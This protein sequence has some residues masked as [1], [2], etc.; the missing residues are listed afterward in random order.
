MNPK[1]SVLVAAYNVSEYLEKCLESIAQQTYKELE[2]IIVDD[3][4]TDDTNQICQQFAKSDSRIKLIQQKN[5][6]LSA[7]RNAGLK[8]ATG[9]FVMFVDGDDFIDKRMVEEL[10]KQN[11]DIVVCGYKTVPKGDIKAPTNKKLSGQDAAIELLTEQENYMVVSWNKLYR[12]E[13]FKDI[14]FPIGKKHEDSLTTYKI[15]AAAKTVVYLDKPLYFYV[16]RSGSIM[17]KVGIKERLAIKMDAAT[18]A[19][20]YFAKQPELLQ[21]AEIS[22][23]LAVFSYLDNIAAGNLK[24]NSKK[25]YDWL[26]Q[27]KQQLLKNQFMTPKLETYI[28]MATKLDGTFYR[29]FRRIKH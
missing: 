24:A 9:D 1:V 17:D 23:L 18:E 15:L 20:K 8:V 29:L 22:E 6:G 4:S 13:L 16:Q 27:N 25:Y 3:G 5:A 7:V 14:K 19:K 28:K 10:V 21:A 11:A 26:E 12:R 2:I